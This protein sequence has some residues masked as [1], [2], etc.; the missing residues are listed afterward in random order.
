[1][2]IKV[3]GFL[4]D[5]SGSSKV[6]K[7]REES[8]ANASSTPD[9]KDF[10]KDITEQL[11]PQSMEVRVIDIKN[12][13]PTSKTYR[14]ESTNGWIPVFQSG[15]YVNFRLKI[16]DSILTR[17]YSISSA[18]YEARTEH[19]YF[20]ITI[21]RNK[22]YL[23][24]DY[25]F[26]N[27][28]M[29]D[30]LDANLPFGYFYYEP[31]RDTKELVALTGGSGVTPF[32]SL[33]REIAYGKLKDVK[34][35]ILYGSVKSDDIIFKDEFDTIMKDCPNVKVIHILSDDP[36]WDGEKGFVDKERI[37]KYSTENST[38]LFSG[39]LPMYHFVKKALEEMGVPQRRFRHDVIANPADITKAPGYPAGTET[40]TF[41]ITVKRGLQEDVIEAKASEPVA[42]ALE[43]AAIQINTHCR[44]GECGM[45]R[46]KLIS[47]EIF[48]PQETDGRRRMDKEFNYFHACS[49]WPLS[50]LT[51][52]IPIM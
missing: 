17:P 16:G 38:Y 42:V 25:F 21:R 48:V 33:A 18:P 26:E 41:H 43:R 34:L 9:P 23:V 2:S 27:V 35:T 30:V 3:K 50:D 39:P 20:E 32:Y 31:L 12:T 49:S 47:G 24:P 45:C 52:Q 10:I 5:V 22:P 6:I 37:Q 44:N 14:F 36:S 28:K 13:S 1:M 4:K 29:G 11:H 7:L 15:Q 8:Y 51:I 46:S 19:P 40:K